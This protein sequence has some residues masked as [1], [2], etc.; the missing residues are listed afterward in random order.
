MEEEVELG[1]GNHWRR[2]K[3]KKTEKRGFLLL[4]GISDLV[5]AFYYLLSGLVIHVR[6]PPK[7]GGDNWVIPTNQKKYS[8][9]N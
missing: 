3:K 7:K 8:Q 4:F 5:V 2:G 9:W 6:L 1:Q